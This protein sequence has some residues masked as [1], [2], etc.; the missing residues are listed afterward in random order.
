M[1]LVCRSDTGKM[2]GENQDSCDAFIYKDAAFLIVA[3]GMGGHNGGQTASRLAAE[4]VRGM[5]ESEYER[6]MSESVLT[7][8]LNSCCKLANSEIWQKSLKDEKLSGM[9]TT[10]VIAAV[11]DKRVTVLNVGDSRAYLVS[12]KGAEALTKD[13]SYVQ[14]LVDTGEISEQEAQNHPQKNIIMQAV[15]SS[16][17]IFPDINTCAYNGETILLCS[18]GL[19]NKVSRECM[20]EILSK[21][22]PLTEK[23]ERLIQ[24]ANDAGGEDNI[25]VVLASDDGHNL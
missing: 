14:H 3:D 19:S 17:D 24:M 2:R 12:Q 9:G 15:G 10:L 8:L 20:E 6:A 7:S 4:C 22:I 21:D 23:A 5:I 18:D 11:T 16:A 13:Q 1:N 25:T